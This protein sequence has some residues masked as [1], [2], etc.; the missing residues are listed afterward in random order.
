M[1]YT[2]GAMQRQGRVDDGTAPTDYDE[3]E[4]ARKMSIACSLAHVEWGKTKI[5]LVDTPGFNM[6]VHE[7]KMVL[8]VVDAAIV[9]VDGVAG[10]EVVTERVWAY[11]EE[12]QTPRLIVASRMDRERAD[13]ERVLE[14]LQKAFG[15]NVIP[16]E[17]PIGSEKNL[18]GVVDLVRMKAYTYE[19]G[20]N[21]KGK[22]IDI[23]AN[24]KEQ[25]QKAHEALVELIAEG[26]DALMEEFFEKGTIPEEDLIPALHNAIREDKIF[27]VIFASGLGN[28]GADRVMDFIVDYTPAPSEHEWVQGDAAASSNGEPPKRHETDNEPVSL[29]IFK[30]VSDPF[31]GRISYFKVFSGVLKNDATVQNF[32]RGSTEKFAHISIQ[33]GKTAVPVPE[34]HA[35][36]IGSVAKLKDTVTG[37][38]LGD[39]SAP[40]Q[41][42]K[43]KL[44]EPAITFAIEPKSRADEDKLG[45][46]IHKMMEEDAMLR[47]FRDGQTKEFLIA[48]TGQQHIEVVVA[49]MKKRY[50]TEVNLKAPKVPY[51]ETIRGRADVQGKHKKQ[52]GG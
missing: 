18:N 11:C 47:F 20:G 27:P 30:T 2:A 32:T 44:P 51:R 22:E 9:V 16:L 21:G 17:L 33:Q 40:I 15:R 36:D 24:M 39:K 41:Y 19:L 12:Y 49:K 38:T 7:A 8:P 52:S 31:S 45:V 26:N 5:N 13:A 3:E 48:G 29:Y 6:F 14:S 35:G 43:V 50:H 4:I 46:G 1:L 37:D 34:L 28:I 42:P 10:V 25:A 23:P